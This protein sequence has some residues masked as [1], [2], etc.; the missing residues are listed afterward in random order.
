MSPGDLRW[1][2]FAQEAIVSPNVW[3]T[4]N[5]IKNGFKASVKLPS[6]LAAGNYVV[7]H[8]IIALHGGSSPN[9]AQLYPQCKFIP[10]L[11]LLIWI[12]VQTLT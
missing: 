1:S 5:L 4:D 12:L 10:S 2:K 7:R 9:G 3:V 6:K 11:Y 8:E